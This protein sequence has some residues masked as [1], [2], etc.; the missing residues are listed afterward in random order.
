MPHSTEYAH[1]R[2]I[3]RVLPVGGVRWPPGPERRT[4]CTW[5]APSRAVALPIRSGGGR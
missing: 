3:V 2:V 5:T 4:S 1:L